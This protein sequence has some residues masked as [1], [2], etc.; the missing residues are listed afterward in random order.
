MYSLPYLRNFE[1]KHNKRTLAMS[2]HLQVRLL[3]QFSSFLCYQWVQARWRLHHRLPWFPLKCLSHKI[4]NL[5][6]NKASL[7]HGFVGIFI[8]SFIDSIKKKCK[9]RFKNFPFDWLLY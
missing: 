1:I 8:C 3:Y 5:N 4:K 2:S 6:V 7:Y 9:W